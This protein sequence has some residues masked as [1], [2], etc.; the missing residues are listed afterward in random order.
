MDKIWG[1]WHN[2]KCICCCL[3]C[4]MLML[5]SCITCVWCMISNIGGVHW[6]WW[7]VIV[8]D[9][10][11]TCIICC[12]HSCSWING[13]LLVSLKSN[14]VDWADKWFWRWWNQWDVIEGDANELETLILG[15]E[16]WSGELEYSRIGTTCIKSSCWVALHCTLVAFVIVLDDWL[17]YCYVTIILWIIVVWIYMEL[18]CGMSDVHV[19]I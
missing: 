2:L 14:C 1:V 4:C 12:T 8:H 9:I 3:L 17:C 5:L 18:C 10:D 15:G 19:I 7:W 6:L 13:M 11:V 16:D